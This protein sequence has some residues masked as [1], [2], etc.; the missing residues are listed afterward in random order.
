MQMIGSN[1]N[2]VHLDNHYH[3]TTPLAL[4][5]KCHFWYGWGDSFI[6]TEP[7]DVPE[8]I[9]VGNK[10]DIWQERQV[11]T[12]KACQVSDIMILMTM[13]MIVMM[14][15]ITRIMTMMM[16]VMMAMIEMI[17]VW[18]E[19]VQEAQEAGYG[20]YFEITT[21]ESLDQVL[22]FHILND[23]DDADDSGDDHHK[24]EGGPYF[25]I[26]I[27]I[28][29]IIVIIVC[30]SGEGGLQWGNP[31]G[32]CRQGRVQGDDDFDNGDVWA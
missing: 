22:N 6:I 8:M 13:T 28:I 17:T 27:I 30:C 25:V 24:G 21:R 23:G 12:D 29:I 16:M 26:I 4:C 20:N 3:H 5:E 18:Q 32:S 1:L 15:T 2:M 31:T 19:C 10:S 7:K 11:V 9:L 14:M